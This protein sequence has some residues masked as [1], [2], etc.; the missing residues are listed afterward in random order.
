M[1][2]R[3]KYPQRVLFLRRTHL[4]SVGPERRSAGGEDRKSLPQAAG[5]TQQTTEID[6]RT[7]LG[8]FEGI[9]LV[10]SIPLWQLRR[11]TPDWN[12]AKRKVEK[13]FADLARREQPVE[14]LIGVSYSSKCE[15]PLDQPVVARKCDL[16]IA[17]F[18]DNTDVIC[19]LVFA[20]RQSCA[21]ALGFLCCVYFPRCCCT[22]K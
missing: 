8:T 16:S 2:S 19:S 22:Q 21:E 5:Q 7:R 20:T 9:Q 12:C 6:H 3:D 1:R 15:Y 11:Q 4:R 14:V 13:T 17:F 10:V 18:H